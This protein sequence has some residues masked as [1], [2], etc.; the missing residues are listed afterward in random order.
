MLELVKANKLQSHY[1]PETCPAGSWVMTNFLF[2]DFHPDQSIRLPIPVATIKGEAP[3]PRERGKKGLG[4][5]WGGGRGYKRNWPSGTYRRQLLRGL[6]QLRAD[7]HP[8][9]VPSLLVRH[10]EG[11]WRPQF[12]T[13]CQRRVETCGRSQRQGATL[14][15]RPLKLGLTQNQRATSGPLPGSR[16]HGLCG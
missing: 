16:R 13:P 8:L 1:I 12:Q 4:R 7:F 3:H 2:C 15:R 9:C 5:G 10:L 11:N 6:R 14:L